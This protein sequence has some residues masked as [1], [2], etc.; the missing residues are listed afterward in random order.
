MSDRALRRPSP[1]FR[2]GLHSSAEITAI[3]FDHY[4]G[5][6]LTG[7]LIPP[8]PTTLTLVV[9]LGQGIHDYWCNKPDGARY[10][11][12]TEVF[13]SAYIVMARNQHQKLSFKDL[14]AIGAGEF[15]FPV[16]LGWQFSGSPY[17]AVNVVEGRWEIARGP[18]GHS[19]QDARLEVIV[20]HEPL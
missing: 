8:V 20:E 12:W 9:N 19:Y 16:K 3:A 18:G 7:D 5:P 10:D 6:T 17:R 11:D 2:S 14:E 1:G 15:Q 4:F 13:G